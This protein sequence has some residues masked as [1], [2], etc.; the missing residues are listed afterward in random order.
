MTN[1]I[2]I[3]KIS[4][5][6][7]LTNSRLEFNIAG[8]DID[9][10]IVNTLRRVCITDIPVYA[11]TNINITENTSIFNNNYL[12]LRLNNLPVLGIKS[13]K[14]IFTNTKNKDIFIEEESNLVN[15]DDINLTINKDD[16]NISTLDKLTMY[17]NYENNTDEIVSVGTNN[18]KFYLKEKQIDSP[19]PI[20]I[21]LIKLHP[22][23][24]I[25]FSAITELGIEK[26][27]SIFSSVSI[28]TFIEKS[29]DNYNII[30]ESRGQLDE[31]EIL[32]MCNSN[33]QNQLDNIGK[34]IPDDDSLEGKLILKKIDHTL[35]NIL[36][37][38]LKR[39]NKVIFSGYSMPH[40]LD[41]KIVIHFKLKE[42]RIKSI[43]D[44][45]LKYYKQI[46][47]NVNEKIKLI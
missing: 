32:D 10:V 17:L 34:L 15:M 43:I 13:K 30:L 44:D 16:V 25:S 5:D 18:C 24:K 3:K 40:P 42:G 41:D 6:T 19:Y 22:K 45:T 46:F 26:S 20:N 8:K 33:I 23:Q 21:Q 7:E 39:H 9:N 14:H 37:S 27:S 11:F 35:G 38:G 1:N 2:N 47:N 4:W 31:K 36:S 12:K 29:S 28:F